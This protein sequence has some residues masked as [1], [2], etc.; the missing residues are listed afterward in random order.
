MDWWTVA[1][2]STTSSNIVRVVLEQGA[3]DAYLDDL[4]RIYH[5]R[6]DVMQAALTLH[7][8]D[9]LR[10]RTPQGGY[11]FW[12][13]LLTGADTSELLA[14]AHAVGVGFVPGARF[15]SQDGLQRHFR[16]SFA[17]FAEDAIEEG[18][19]RLATVM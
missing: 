14:Q 3:Q 10:F 9:R 5:R 8:G 4:R 18:I 17:H 11:F 1:A 6:I 13:E 16:L 15:S 12:L 7:L 2:A 19:A